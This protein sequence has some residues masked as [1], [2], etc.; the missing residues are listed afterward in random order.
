MD[1]DAAM[2]LQT[3]LQAR[4]QSCICDLSTLPLPRCKA[5]ATCGRRLETDAPSRLVAEGGRQV[6]ATATEPSL[7]LELFGRPRLLFRRFLIGVADYHRLERGHP[8][9]SLMP[10]AGYRHNMRHSYG[11]PATIVACRTW[12]AHAVGRATYAADRPSFLRAC[13]VSAHPVVSPSL[14]TVRASPVPR[15][16]A[17][18]KAQNGACRGRPQ[19]R[20]HTLPSGDFPAPCELGSHPPAIA[21][22]FFPERQTGCKPA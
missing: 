11:V 4:K 16:L 13:A 2:V 12:A 17:L 14:C 7:F 6:Q 22:M 3:R 18:R 15:P 1:A 8:R 20:S 10:L 21:R 5:R 9:A 19:R